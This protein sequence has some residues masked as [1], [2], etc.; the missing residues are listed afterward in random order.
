M[1]VCGQSIRFEC[2][3]RTSFLIHSFSPLSPQFDR[4]P[5]TDAAHNTFWKRKISQQSSVNNCITLELCPKEMGAERK[6]GEVEFARSLTYCA[7]MHAP[8]SS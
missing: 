8:V 6:Y 1:E 7:V 4:W 3:R 5:T 2:C